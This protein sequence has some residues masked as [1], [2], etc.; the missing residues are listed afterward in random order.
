MLLAIGMAGTA[1]ADGSGQEQRR[2]RS[3]AAR[4]APG[5]GLLHRAEGR[6]QGP[7]QSVRRRRRRLQVRLRLRPLGQHG[8]IGANLAAGRQ[9]RVAPQASKTSTPS[10]SSSSSSTTS[11]RCVFNPTGTPGR[12]AFATEQNKQRAARFIDSITAEGGTAHEEALK[13]A[14]RL[15]PDVIFFLTD[16]DDP[17]LTPAQ[18]EK[19]RHLAAGIVINAIEFGP[20][21]KP[22]GESFLAEL[23]RQNGGGYVYVDVSRRRC[24]RSLARRGTT[25]R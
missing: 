24:R 5:P 15:Q 9:G 14:I 10:T 2:G 3:V 1:L 12:L 13:L 25:V 17:K 23:A 11:G 20:G 16:A 18:L 22:P 21:P 4:A 8:R 19:I 6:R 7:H